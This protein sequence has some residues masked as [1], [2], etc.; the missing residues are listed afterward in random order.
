MGVDPN[1]TRRDVLRCILS[2]AAL[3]VISACGDS[4]IEPDRSVTLQAL[5]ESP[6]KYLD[7]RLAIIANVTFLELRETRPATLT[8]QHPSRGDANFR[9]VAHLGDAASQH[10]LEVIG[11]VNMSS[12]AFPNVSQFDY[13]YLQ[14]KRLTPEEAPSTKVE[15]IGTIQSRAHGHGYYFLLESSRKV[16]SQGTNPHDPALLVRRSLV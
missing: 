2:T 1:L 3:P 15:M 11:Y 16:K 12:S 9:Y 8:G 4:R 6:A 7:Q 13:L 5:I 10:G 14:A